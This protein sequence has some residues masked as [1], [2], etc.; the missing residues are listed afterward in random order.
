MKSFSL[1]SRPGTKK[2]SF[3][4]SLCCVENF[5]TVKAAKV[6]GQMF[7][8]RNECYQ[9]TNDFPFLRYFEG[10]QK[11]HSEVETIKPLDRTM[12]SRSPLLDLKL[13]KLGEPFLSRPERKKALR[14]TR[15]G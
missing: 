15:P 5:R 6:H 10:R 13:P 14:N 8:V 1:K 3:D 7:L 4:V 9:L 2:Y 12:E 11:G